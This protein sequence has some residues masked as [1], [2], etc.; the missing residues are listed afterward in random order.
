MSLPLWPLQN[1]MMAQI[2][3]KINWSIRLKIWIQEAKE[4]RSFVDI[5]RSLSTQLG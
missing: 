2:D 3:K 4:T 1:E 5:R